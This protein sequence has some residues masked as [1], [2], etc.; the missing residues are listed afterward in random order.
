[1]MVAMPAIG[2]DLEPNKTNCTDPME[3]RQVI[4][5]DD[6]RRRFSLFAICS[7]PLLGDLA[8]VNQPKILVIIEYDQGSHSYQ[9]LCE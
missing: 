2:H 7:V 5:G 4:G 9:H 8:I 3:V 1:M 6:V